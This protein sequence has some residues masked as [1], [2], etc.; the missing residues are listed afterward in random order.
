MPAL[1]REGDDF[2]GVF[3][4]GLDA[5]G[6]LTRAGVDGFESLEGAAAGFASAALAS[7]AG[8]GFASDAP[9]VGASDLAD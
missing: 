4:E 1:P 2:A 8:A 6:M 3:A 9:V 7:A 5:E